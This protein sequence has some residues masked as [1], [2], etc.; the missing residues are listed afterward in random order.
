V[1]ESSFA[2]GD[3]GQIHCKCDT[4]QDIQYL[5]TCTIHTIENFELLHSILYYL[6]TDKGCFTTFLEEKKSQMPKCNPEDV[7]AIA[8]R[9]Q[10]AELK[11]KA[12]GF[13]I[14][15]CCPTNIL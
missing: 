1:F 13:L 15:T 12:L 14:E 7:F 6:Y 4:S 3:G 11:E 10:L 2:E 8:N 9:F 5:P